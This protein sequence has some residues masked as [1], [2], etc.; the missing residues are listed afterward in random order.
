[1]SARAAWTA[2]AAVA[3]VLAAVVLARWAS[4]VALGGPVLYGEGA[5][6]NAA[7]LAR[8]GAEYAEREAP[9]FVAANYTPLFFHLAGL[10]DPFVAGRLVSIAAALGIAG[11]VAWRARRGGAA[12]AVALGAGSVA[13]APLA[14]WGPAVK[15]DILAVGL[16]VAGVL[17]VDARRPA[18]GGALLVLACAAKPTAVIPA[19]A[20]AGALAWRRS[21]NALASYAAV[22][23]LATAVFVAATPGGIPALRRHAIDRNA[24]PWD[25]QQ[26]LL[27]VVLAVLLVGAVAIGG[28]LSRPRPVIAAYLAGAWGVLL[29]GGREGA[30][31]NY[32]L[33]VSA[34]GAL[35]L[36]DAAPL[37]AARSFLPVLGALQ[38]AAGALVVDPYGLRSGAT[39]T[40]A[41]GAP[42]RV[43]VARALPQ[44]RI[45]AEDAGL[46]VATGR[47]PV[48]D[49][50]FLWSR[51]AERGAIDPAP[52]ERAVSEGAFARVVAETDLEAI[53][54]AP[55][56][57][58]QRWRR[59]LV[60][61]VLARYVLDR[62]E[63]GL[64]VYR[65]R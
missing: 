58:R 57:E 64:H 24:L 62:A 8:D 38:L 28:A 44:G 59:S 7:I 16:T 3:V 34:A 9:A 55:S 49:D 32:A 1:M 39:A 50:L 20:I 29:L 30:T 11:A 35:A 18:I 26:A 36:A 43:A 53:D 41:W 51:L 5:V 10:G 19:L 6:A 27:L 47:D 13:L 15:P 4:A 2:L 42:Q 33:D 22:G 21:W 25:P 45:L 48:V 17:A 61:A 60:D 52:L 14:I 63:G 31:I 65:P 56:Y 46:L 40:G 12:V 54:R 23:V 37:L